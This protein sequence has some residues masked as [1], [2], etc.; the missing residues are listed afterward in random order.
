MKHTI[1]TFIL[2]TLSAALLA[3][4]AGLRYEDY[5]YKNNLRTVQLYV[6]G[7]F[8]SQPIIELGSNSALV[9]SFDDMDANVKNYTYTIVHCDLNW[10]PSNLAEMEYINGFVEDRIEQFEFSFQTLTPYTH[11]RLYLPNRAQS[12]TKSGNYLL[13]VYEDEREKTLAI[14]RRF[15][16]VESLVNIRPQMVRPNAV[17]KM[18]THQELDFVVDFN[19]LNIRD[20]QREVRATV[21]QNG[22]WDNAIIDIPPLF[23]RGTQLIF[24]YQ[25]RVIFPAGKEFRYL[26]MRSL[27]FGS[28]NLTAV[29]RIGDTYEVTLN[30]DQ[31]RFNQVYLNRQDLNGMYVIETFDQEDP[32]LSSNYA[33]VLFSLYSPE[34]LYDYDVYLFGKL[35]DWRID[36]RYK[37][38]YNPLV[39]GYVGKVQLKEGYYDYKYAVV[40]REGKNRTANLTEIEGDWYETENQYTILLY[41]R[42]FGERYDRVISV[43]SVS[44]TF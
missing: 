11:Y 37:M 34:P 28:E 36:E 21:L 1:I 20:P 6:D 25:D 39:N 22:R 31:K 18:R 30:K 8:T 3:Q 14:T 12:F 24:D 27:R 26:D 23:V 13:K 35:T 4:D 44:S 38:A 15:V 2:G 29:E 42:P 7:L 33:N 5:T 19:R 32:F 43:I 41:Y 16:V 10:Q 17:S 9:L 40:P